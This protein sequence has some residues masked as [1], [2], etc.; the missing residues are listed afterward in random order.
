[1][2]WNVLIDQFYEEKNENIL[3]KITFPIPANKTTLKNMANRIGNPLYI[4]FL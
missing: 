4:I 2:I 3:P 1:M